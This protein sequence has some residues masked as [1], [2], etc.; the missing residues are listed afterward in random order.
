VDEGFNI[1][2]EYEGSASLFRGI[3]ST[4][5]GKIGPL[6]AAATMITATA[7]LSTILETFVKI[8]RALE[9]LTAEVAREDVEPL[10]RKPIF[11]ILQKRGNKE[12]DTLAF[13]NRNR[14]KQPWFIADRHH[15]R[16]SFLGR[17]E[18]L[19]FAP[20]D[21]KLIES[22]LEV[23][24]LD[25]RKLSQLVGSETS[26]IGIPMPNEKYTK[27]LRLKVPFITA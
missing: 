21:L 3:L 7:K 17:T 5:K 20:E 19:A 11:P 12:Y 2:A 6:V 15:L 22:L 25:S 24:E 1:A 27:H 18:L 8:S 13:L 26:P 16:D 23:L 9:G 14:K 10:R 4:G